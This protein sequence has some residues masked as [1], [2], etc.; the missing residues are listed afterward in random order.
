MATPIQVEDITTGPP[1]V[2]TYTSGDKPNRKLSLKEQKGHKRGGSG[3]RKAEAAVQDHGH[4]IPR[5]NSK[6][7]I[8]TLAGPPEYQPHAQRAVTTMA[9]ASK[10]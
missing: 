6:P 10:N 2:V 1:T 3:G 9:A 8:N 4:V 7:Q 5:T